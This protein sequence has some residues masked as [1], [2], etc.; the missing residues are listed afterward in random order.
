MVFVFEEMC[1]NGNQTGGGKD[2]M[3][4][5]DLQEI[6]LNNICNCQI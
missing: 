3:K 4:G 2:I 5:G 6:I 1:D